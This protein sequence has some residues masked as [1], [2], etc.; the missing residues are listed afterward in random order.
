MIISE[1]PVQEERAAPAT[2]RETPKP[3]APPETIAPEEPPAPPRRHWLRWLLILAFVVLAVYLV[4]HR[5]GKAGG[6]PDQQGQTQG[7]GGK[8]EAGKGPER[9][10]PVL[11]AAAHTKDVGVY[12]TGLGTVSPLNTVTVKSRVDGQ[13][14]RIAF[15]EG[16]VVRAGELLAEIDP[17]PFQ[18]Q[19]AQAEGQT[20]KD[21]AALKNARV[22]LQRYQA[23]IAQDA[24][25]QQQLDTQVATVD[26]L[27]AALKS[28]Q[29]Q[30]DG[31]QAQSHLRRITAPISGRVG[32]RLVDPGN[33]VHASDA[34][35]LVVITQLQPIAVVV[36]HPRRHL[37]QVLQQVHA[38]QQPRR[39]RLRP[40]SARSKLATGT[41]LAVDNQIDP[42][43]RHRQAQG[44]VRQRERR[45]CS[46]ISSSTPGCSSTRCAS[47]V[48]V[49]TAA[50]QRSPQA[51]FVYVVKPDHTVE[52]RNVTVQSDRGRRRRHR[53]RSPAGRGG[54]DRRR[55]QAAAGHESRRVDDGRERS[56]GRQGHEPLA[57]LHPAAGRDVAA[58]GGPAARGRRRVSGS[59]RSRRCRRSTTRR[60]R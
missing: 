56:R 15:Q 50:L 34:N 40:R 60:S 32:L 47:A 53:E 46:P 12:L 25:P 8:A 42:H 51:T 18:V 37:P 11:A 38:G 6:E 23:L 55:G 24:I 54:G 28:D 27:E 3:E 59:S 57:A 58:D 49:P 17:R 19:L 48:I 35:G 13:L 43:D 10:V 1:P 44:H 16:Q 7:K 9:P 41:L 4:M 2:A 33:I 29:A 5:P 36:H 30:I 52:S 31:A 26:Q 21:E 39:G 14:L 22:D 20:A 45:R